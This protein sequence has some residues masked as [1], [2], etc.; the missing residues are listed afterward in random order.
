[1]EFV[2]M[3]ALAPPEVNMPVEL[4]EQYE[5]DLLVSLGLYVM[6]YGLYSDVD[7]RLKK[8]KKEENNITYINFL[9]K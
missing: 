6:E 3:P 2:E 7:V 8:K 4:A 1:M 5:R 9:I